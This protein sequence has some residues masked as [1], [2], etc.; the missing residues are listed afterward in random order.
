MFRVS[1]VSRAAVTAIFMPRYEQSLKDA[2]A[3]LGIP[4]YQELMKKLDLY[5]SLQGAY[6]VKQSEMERTRR[7][8]NVCGLDIAPKKRVPRA[9][10]EGTA[11][12]SSSGT[13]PPPA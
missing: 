13:P 10:A 12:A 1:L 2:E 6:A 7:V 8:A 3:G 11:P 9:P 4:E 5:K